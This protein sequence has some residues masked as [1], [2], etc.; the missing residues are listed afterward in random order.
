MWSKWYW[1]IP[2]LM[3]LPIVA[4]YVLSFTASR[5]SNLGV[6]AGKLAPCPDSPNCVST[7]ADDEGHRIAP[8]PFTGTTADA[9]TK[10]KQALAALPRARIIMESADYLHVECTSLIFRFVDDVEFYIDEPNQVIHAR[11]ASRVGRGDLGVNRQ[12]MDAI[13]AALEKR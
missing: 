2:A 12:R 5:P 7:Q 13:R 3:V 6:T 1:L 4:L 9:M 10:I 8:I 11:S